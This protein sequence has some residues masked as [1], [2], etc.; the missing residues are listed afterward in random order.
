MK[1]NLVFA[2]IAVIMTGITLTSCGKLPQT[3]VDAAKAAIESLR[4][5]QT[6]IYVADEFTSLQDSLTAALENVE[7]TSSKFLF[8]NYESAKIQLEAVIAKSVELG[9]KT[10]V[11]KDQVKA[12]AEAALAAA[13]T[14][15]EENMKLIEKAP[16]GKE[17]KAALDAIKGELSVLET[18][19]AETGT[20][21]ETGSFIAA[22]DKVAAASEKLNAIN[23]ELKEVIA[24]VRR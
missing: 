22:K 11:A 5:Q 20:L 2:V 7:K 4:T 10:Q 13:K 14:I 9:E 24:K 1:K 17:G 21:I 8:R 15:M 3:E 23:V 6:D 18:S 12:E 19:L 16:K